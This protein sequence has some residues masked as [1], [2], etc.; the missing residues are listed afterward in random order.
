MSAKTKPGIGAADPGDMSAIVASF[1]ALDRA[2]LH[3]Q[4]R[5]HLGGAAPAH[6]PRW[7]LMRVL[8]YR[9]QAQAFGDLDKATLRVIRAAG[10]EGGV[11]P[12][13]K[14][15]ASTRDGIEL[16]P[17]SLL[18]REWKGKLERVTALDEGF[19]WNGW[20]YDSLSQVAKAITGTSWNGHRF[21]GLK[22]ARTGAPVSERDMRRRQGVGARKNG[23]NAFAAANGRAKRG[24]E[25]ESGSER[26]HENDSALETC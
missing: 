23:E 25:S 8:V 15:A 5:N 19:A 26:A 7:L 10:G 13:A 17:G 9:M 4:W 2:D 14:R 16:K 18:T 11:A 20:T 1:E 24:A 22:Q 12:F 21:F 3:L 6:L